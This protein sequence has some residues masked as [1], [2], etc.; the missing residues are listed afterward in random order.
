MAACAPRLQSDNRAAFGPHQVQ[1]KG[2]FFSPS[3]L[4]LRLRTSSA[5]LKMVKRLQLSFFSSNK[6]PPKII[7][8]AE[9]CKWVDAGEMHVRM[10]VHCHPVH[11]SSF[12]QARFTVKI[13]NKCLFPLPSLN[14]STGILVLCLIL[15][16]WF[17]CPPLLFYCFGEMCRK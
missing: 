17:Q 7:R 15:L 8:S 6:I 16:D 4:V 11:V 12:S 5:S 14:L 9:R 13:L 1:Q 2:C 10:V 3:K